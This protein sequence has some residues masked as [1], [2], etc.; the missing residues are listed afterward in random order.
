[1]KVAHTSIDIIEE[2]TAKKSSDLYLG[3]LSSLE[4]LAVYGYVTDTKIKFI[5]LLAL[6]DQPIK[7]A[8]VKNVK[9]HIFPDLQIF[10]KIH[11]SWVNHAMNPFWDHDEE[12]ISDDS[13][14]TNYLKSLIK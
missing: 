11:S 7:D 12:T 4:D 1:M 2:R 10:K 13:K 8:D 3:L 5:L 14:F 6:K 9:N